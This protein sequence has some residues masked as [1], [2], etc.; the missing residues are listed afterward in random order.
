MK[1]LLTADSPKAIVITINAGDIPADHWVHDPVA[2][3]GRIIGEGCHFVDLARYLAG[4][5][6]TSIQGV[7][8]KK[9]AGGPNLHDVAVATLGFADGS[10]ATIAYLA[11]GHRGFPKER[12]EVFQSGK[13]LQLDNFRMLRGFGYSG[14]SKMKTFSQ[15]K[16]HVA[17]AQAT[18]DALRAGKPAPIPFAELMEVSR[19]AISLQEAILPR[20]D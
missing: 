13:I 6:I 1:S 16:G 15:D 10:I 3:G 7:D 14:F 9:P 4:A 8:T 17:C 18:L 11:N 2:G 19:A 5:A 20:A 12:I